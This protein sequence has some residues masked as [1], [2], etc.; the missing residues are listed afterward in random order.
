MNLHL[1]VVLV[2][3]LR[4]VTKAELSSQTFHHAGNNKA[5]LLHRATYFQR[6]GGI[7]YIRAC[8]PSASQQIQKLSGEMHTCTP[9]LRFLRLTNTPLQPK[10]I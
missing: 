2:A 4:H 1:K 5:C 7:G 3:F 10:F 8:Q 6:R 9:S